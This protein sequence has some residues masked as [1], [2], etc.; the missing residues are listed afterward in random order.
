[1]MRQLPPLAAVRV[2]EAAA[3]HLN[4]T[5]AAAELGMTQAAVSYQMR[6]LE[7]RLGAPLFRRD[8]GRVS[9]TEAG[10]RAAPLVSG[11]FDA[12]GEAFAAARSEAG[13]VLTISAANT[14]AA[15][16]L[17]PR[18]GRFQ[19]RHPDLAVRLEASNTLVDFARD[20]ADVA[21]RLTVDPGPGLAADR[22]FPSAF[23]PMASPAF[24]A[25]HPLGTPADLLTAARISPDDSWWRQWFETAGVTAPAAD[26]R[27]ALLLDSQVIEGASALAGNGVA[28]LNVRFWAADLAAGRLVMPFPIVAES[29]AYF[30]LVCPEARRNVPKIRYFREWLLAEVAAD[31]GSS[32]EPSP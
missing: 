14:I 29:G 25:A 5:R 17:A 27:G 31:Q 12:L 8:K 3:R 20:A 22:L 4:F 21:I 30:W 2:F 7:E 26:R 13:S 1:M 9:L 32:S 10:R 24:L 23:A 11:A 15:N 19:L 18:L 16:W 6:V 28:L